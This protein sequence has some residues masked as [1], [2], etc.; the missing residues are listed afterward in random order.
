MHGS[1]EPSDATAPAGRPDPELVLTHLDGLP[2]LSAIAVRL[3]KVTTDGESSASDVIKLLRGD[4]SLT[5]KILS[6][7]SSAWAGVPGSATTLE[8]AIPLLGFRTVRSI[9]L[10]VS[11]FECFPI[12]EPAAADDAF[13]RKEFWK[14]ALAVACAARGLASVRRDMGVDPEEAF[15]G[16]LL[17]D[18]G[19]VALSAIFPKAYSRI[20][21]Q[22][23]DSRGDIADFE[24]AVLGTDH[25]V[26]G[27]RLA[28]NWRL[29]PELRDEIWLHHLGTDVLPESVAKPHLIGIAQLADTIARE[30]RIG[31]S[32]N[33]MFYEHSPRLAER[34]GFAAADI[35]TVVESL[36][37]DVVAQA[38][39]LGVDDE[40]TDLVYLRAMTRANA[41]LGRLNA[42]L[43]SS[44]RQLAAGA[45]YFLAISKFDQILG[46]W[47]DPPAVVAAMARSAAIALQRTKVVAFGLRDYWAAID[48]SWVHDDP[49]RNGDVSQRVPADLADWLAE[50][51]ATTDAVLTQA[52]AAICG[53]LPPALDDL[54]RGT[55]WL[56]PVVHDGRLA[57]GVVFRSENDERTRLATETEDLRSFVASLGLALGRANAQAAARRLADDLAETNRRLQQA[58]V[59]L[60]R[61]R[62]LSMIAEM[63]AG[64][65]HELNG[66]LTVISGRAQMLASA[67]RDPETERSLELIRGKAH[68]CSQIVSELM[69]FARPRPPTLATVELEEL[70]A[71]VRGDWLATA[72]VPQS[73]LQLDVQ[74]GAAG[75]AATDAGGPLEV[76]GDRAQLKTVFQELIDNSADAVSGNSGMIH[77][78]CRPA[79]TDGY[80]EVIVRDTGCGM[81]PAV[82]QRAFD[83]FYS[84]RN[85]GRGRGL[86]LARAYRIIEGHGGRIWLESAPDEGTMAHV[87]LPRAAKPSSDGHP[88]R[89]ANPK[90]S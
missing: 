12:G 28:E 69:D 35:D 66:P 84:H 87:L 25:T 9:V 86:G 5:A 74:R 48:I 4:Q 70:V 13:N 76:M 72:R 65:G 23:N 83:P 11:V 45:R 2:T 21:A 38:R 40:A 8:K 24:R 75:R 71:E 50:P 46:A 1:R 89:T 29:P 44:S 7:A 80:I 78:T 64:A 6:V 77:I 33:H 27:R 16:G 26:A 68:E 17:H 63:A 90:P 32:G 73:G 39:A 15:V 41:E 54:G 43:S 10:A 88:K 42:E 37:T 56:V 85:A 30:Q 58:Q 57:G 3:L 49:G 18:L 36:V 62:T 19:K 60:L 31:Y 59:E 47:S 51:G 22:A 81:V 67:L 55:A 61:S 79:V 53:I 52:P 82:L 14:H 34:L 20:A